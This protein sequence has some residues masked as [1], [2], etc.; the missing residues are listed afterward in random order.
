MKAKQRVYSNLFCWLFQTSSTLA[1]FPLRI[2]LGII[3]FAHGAQKLFGW[4]GG[5][6]LEGTASSFAEKLHLV[7][8][9]FWATLA[10]GGEFLGAV[11][12]LLGLATRIAAL[13][14]VIIMT[15]AIFTAHLKAFFVHDGGM[16]Y[17]LSLWAGAFA[18]L[19]GGGGSL[20]LDKVITR[21]KNS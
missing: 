14:L 19:I 16:E 1:F 4:F 17:A 8:G 10:G 15:V 18:L 6:G 7:P 20:S 3:F 13:N 12:L 2:V 11:L 5:K 9:I 21:S